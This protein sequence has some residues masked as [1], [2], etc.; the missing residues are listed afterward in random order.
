MIVLSLGKPKMDDERAEGDR[1]AGTED[2]N[3]DGVIAYV[4]R[5]TSNWVLKPE[6]P[7]TPETAS[8]IPLCSA[9]PST[10]SWIRPQKALL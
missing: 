2:S 4:S 9:N 6:F 3:L 5:Q 10:S 1:M 8:R 7:E